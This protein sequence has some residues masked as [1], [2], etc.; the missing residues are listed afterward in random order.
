[1]RSYE[2]YAPR[3]KK[4][5]GAQKPIVESTESRI[6]KGAAPTDF[7]DHHDGRMGRKEEAAQVEEILEKLLE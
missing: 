6:T 5:R 7:K 1:M 2:E 4:E 3:Q